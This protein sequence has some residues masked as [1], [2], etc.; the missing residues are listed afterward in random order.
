MFICC[1]QSHVH[2]PLPLPTSIFYYYYYFGSVESLFYSFILLCIYWFFFK[3]F[4]VDVFFFFFFLVICDCISNSFFVHII[5]VVKST[6]RKKTR[7]ISKMC[8]FF[9]FFFFGDVYA[10]GT[11]QIGPF[12]FPNSDRHLRCPVV[13]CSRLW[14]PFFF[15]NI[16]IYISPHRR[17]GGKRPKPGIPQGWNIWE[18]A[19]AGPCF[20]W[21]HVFTIVVNPTRGCVCKEW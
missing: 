13:V 9:F 11:T 17:D 18:G 20:P 10:A 5:V 12:S 4:L 19:V 6:W 8:V 2:R 15:F 21:F 16:D 1:V 3:N 7:E 14:E